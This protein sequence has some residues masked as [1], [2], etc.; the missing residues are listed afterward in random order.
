MDGGWI[1]T[2][3]MGALLVRGGLGLHQTGMVRSK[4]AA[5]AGLRTVADLSIALLATWVVGAAIALSHSANGVLGLNPSML[6]AVVPSASAG[7][8]LM[9]M[10]GTILATSIPWGVMAER[11]RFLPQLWAT[12]LLSIAVVPISAYWVLSPNGWLN[13]LG[14]IDAGGASVF[15]LTGGIVALVG[16]FAVGPRGNKYNRDGSSNAIPGHSVPLASAGLLLVAAGW[17]PY[18]IGA[19]GGAN[20][21]STVINV[22]MMLAAG[23]LAAMLLGYFRF[24]KVDVHLTYAGL[25][26]ALIASA[27]GAPYIGARGAALS[28]L[29]AGAIVPIL[30]L[31]LDV[32]WRLDDPTGGVA[33]HAGGATVGLLMAGPFAHS[34]HLM[35]AIKSL[36]TQA[37]GILAIA[38]LALLLGWILFAIL[39]RTCVLRANEADE[40]DGLDLAEHDIGAYPDFQQTTIK[41]YHL[42][43]A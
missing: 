34:R 43:E 3:A 27:A 2:A 15:Q 36:G 26:G 25:L 22:L 28:G 38:A 16:G 14:F 6:L 37:M 39:Q 12:L 40:Y 33:I 10:L 21:G 23:A 5:G 17:A 19:S 9:L 20:A 11:G 31:A 8:L 18:L 32:I 35:P 4:N 29:A 41:S 7:P 13:R 24:G 30:I 42:R 1:L